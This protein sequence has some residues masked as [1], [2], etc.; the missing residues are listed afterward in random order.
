MLQSL[1]R[2]DLGIKVGW[3]LATHFSLKTKGKYPVLHPTHEGTHYDQLIACS[4]L[5][6]STC[7]INLELSNTLGFVSIVKT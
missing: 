1:S 3:M 6:K 7:K 5:K 4:N 2:E